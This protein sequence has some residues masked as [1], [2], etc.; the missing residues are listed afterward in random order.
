MNHFRKKSL[1]SW[2]V[3]AFCSANNSCDKRF[4]KYSFENIV[5]FI[6]FINYQHQQF[7]VPYSRLISFLLKK[8]LR[9]LGILSRIYTSFFSLHVWITLFHNKSCLVPG[10]KFVSYNFR[11]DSAWIKLVN[12][13]FRRLRSS[14]YCFVQEC[15]CWTIKYT[16]L[17][18]LK[19]LR[20]STLVISR[21][22]IGHKY[23]NNKWDKHV[24][25][26]LTNIVN[27]YVWWKTMLKY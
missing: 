14:G 11:R 24:F 19:S 27:V 9:D 6:I 2:E 22:K 12:K 25:S 16:S 21:W 1:N 3:H 5:L 26:I 23:V 7:L 18:G 10:R 20:L 15:C 17:Y 13:I 4:Q 8:Q